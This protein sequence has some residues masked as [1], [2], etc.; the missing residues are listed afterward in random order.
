M[1]RDVFNELLPSNESMR[2]NT[3]HTHIHIYMLHI[4]IQITPKIRDYCVRKRTFPDN[5][6]V[7]QLVKKYT[8]MYGTE[9]SIAAF[10][11]V[12]RWIPT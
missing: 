12:H 6:I 2:H 10:T 9:R 8:A 1:L 11:T 3:F 7:S 4:C 5:L